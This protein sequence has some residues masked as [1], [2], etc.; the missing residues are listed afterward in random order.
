M[1]VAPGGELLDRRRIELIGRGL[2]THPHHREGS[3]AVGRYLSTPGARVV[4]LAEAVALVERV[5]TA[6]KWG[7]REGLEALAA[8]VPVPIVRI[9]LRACPQLRPTTEERIAD[10]RAQTLADSVM[11]RETLAR[12]AEARGWS[13]HWYERERVFRDAAVALGREDVEGVVSA[14]GRSIGPPG[15]ARHKL[16]AAAALAATGRPGRYGPAAGERGIRGG[17]VGRAAAPPASG[18]KGGR[19]GRRVRRRRARL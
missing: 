8:A 18:G 7:A 10:N 12:A 4:S 3:W 13:V 19:G 17:G 1:T 11:Y 16:A 5:R 15:Q 2:P 6:A 14:M 9:A